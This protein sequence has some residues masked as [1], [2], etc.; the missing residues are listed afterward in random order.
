MLNIAT[1]A[2]KLKQEFEPSK[3]RKQSKNGKGTY[4][5]LASIQLGQRAY[6]IHGVSSRVTLPISTLQMIYTTLIMTT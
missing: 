2:Y 4:Q 1:I 6:Q 5:V 3:R